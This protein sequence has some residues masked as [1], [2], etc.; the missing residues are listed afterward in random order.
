MKDKA[1]CRGKPRARSNEVLRSLG[2]CEYRRDQETV[3]WLCFR[4]KGQHA[5]LDY[6]YTY[7]YP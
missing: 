6:V 3:R 4:R 1:V 2:P 5:L 7:L